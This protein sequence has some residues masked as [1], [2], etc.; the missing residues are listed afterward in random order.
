MAMG[1]EK[2][3]VTN[4]AWRICTWL[5]GFWLI[6]AGSNVLADSRE[7]FRSAIE[8]PD[9]VIFLRHALAPGLGDPENFKVDDCSTQRNLS[10]V[11]RDQAQRIG[12]RL[13]AVGLTEAEV[14]SSQWC[15]CLDTADLLDLGEVEPLPALNSFFQR[16]KERA[17]R[18]T[19]L[20]EW[21]AEQ[22][23]EAPPILVTHQVTIT[24][25]TG[26]YP[27]SGELV[28]AEVKADGEVELVARL[29]TQY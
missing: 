6:V 17:P 10:E 19:E 13:R 21:L 8:A 16:P 7:A 25:L 11:G 28:L 15:R 2:R 4:L 26:V 3:D 14:Y 12:E 18:L 9:H 24:A 29:K 22:D 5:C 20:R 23:F 1:N 27:D